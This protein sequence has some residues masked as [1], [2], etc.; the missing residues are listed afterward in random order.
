MTTLRT[1]NFDEKRFDCDG[2]TFYLKDSLSFNRYRKLQE[3]MLEFGYSATYQDIFNNLKEAWEK[4]N[5]LKL[6]ESA[7]II[8]NVMNGI[9]KIEAKDDVSFR[10]C[11]LFLDETD[12]DPTIYDEGRMKSKIECW[13]KEL[14]VMPFFHLAASLVPGW[15]TDYL[16][17]IQNGL[18]EMAKNEAQGI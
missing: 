17:S 4:L 14:D 5:A 7:V 10:L 15:T 6:G 16:L 8:H 9:T 11:A 13:A 12:E 3:F 18:K 2:K 1:V